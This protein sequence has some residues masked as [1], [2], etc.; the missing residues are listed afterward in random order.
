MGRIQEEEYAPF[1][2]ITLLTLKVLRGCL[3]KIATHTQ[4]SDNLVQLS[5]IKQ[6]KSIC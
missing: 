5:S 1:L 4:P 2:I 3:K 6:D